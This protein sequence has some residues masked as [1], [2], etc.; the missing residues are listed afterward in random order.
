[1]RG[2]IS[3]EESRKTKERQIEGISRKH[4]NG[5]Y[6]S[7]KIPFGIGW[8]KDRQEWYRNEREYTVLLEMIRLL[9][10]GAGVK[11]ISSVFNSDPERWPT[12]LYLAMK[13][14]NYRPVSRQPGKRKPK[15]E[16]WASG[17]IWVI[18]NSDFLFDG[19]INT[20]A[21]TIDTG[22]KL[23]SRNEVIEARHYMAQRTRKVSNKMKVV[24]NRFLLRRL[25]RCGACGVY[26]GIREPRNSYRCSKCGTSF[27]NADRIDG[28]V[29][30]RIVETFGDKEKLIAAIQNQEFVADRKLVDL[31]RDKTTA[32]K[33]LEGLNEGKE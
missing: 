24:P 28:Q 23:F 30:D 29:W 31:E 12:R 7:G 14:P 6:A 17:T 15:S 5:C 33:K 3:A 11:K 2:R 22:I 9:K 32:L 13:D 16:Y 1:M 4:R 10:A 21:G 26:L 20:K 25:I 19:L 18:A 27:S 8:N